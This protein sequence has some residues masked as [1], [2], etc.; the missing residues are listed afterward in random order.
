MSVKSDVRRVTSELVM[1]G[2]FSASLDPVWYVVC[3]AVILSLSA[4]SS[5]RSIQVEGFMPGG[6]MTEQ[7][8]FTTGFSS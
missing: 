6:A 3:R 8:R 7:R 5:M 1:S 4:L 2:L